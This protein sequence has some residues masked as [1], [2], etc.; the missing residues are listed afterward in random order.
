MVGDHHRVNLLFGIWFKPDLWAFVSFFHFM[1]S[2]KPLA[3]SL[4]RADNQLRSKSLISRLPRATYN[5]GREHTHWELGRLFHAKKFPWICML[6]L[7]YSPIPGA[8]ATELC[9]VLK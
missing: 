9:S 7:S 2:S 3:F 5:R 4:E 6:K 1:D 8:L